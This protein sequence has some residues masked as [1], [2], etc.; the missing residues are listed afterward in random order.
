MLCDPTVG[1]TDDD[2]CV[3]FAPLVGGGGG[4]GEKPGGEVRSGATSLLSSPLWFRILDWF[5]IFCLWIS[6]AP[7]W[8]PICECLKFAIKSKQVGHQKSKLKNGFKAYL[9]R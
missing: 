9:I 3:K 2:G 5:S 6:D 8:T 7:Q 1:L 4:Y